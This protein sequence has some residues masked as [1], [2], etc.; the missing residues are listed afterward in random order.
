MTKLAKYI[1]VQNV[2]VSQTLKGSRNFT[3]DQVHLCTEYLGLE[4]EEWTYFMLMFQKEKAGHYKLKDKI[5]S[6]LEELGK[7]FMMV[8]ARF[9]DKERLAEDIRAEFYSSVYYPLVRAAVAIQPDNSK[10]FPMLERFGLKLSV[11]GEHLNK[12]EQMGLIKQTAIGYE[13][14]A[15]RTYL[16]KDSP[17]HKIYCENLEKILKS[18][19]V[20]G[21]PDDNFKYLG[22]ITLSHEAAKKIRKRL[23]DLLEEN[24]KTISDSKSEELR[25]FNIDFRR[26]L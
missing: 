18:E 19:F 8:S 12:L 22:M 2:I 23:L 7:K 17:L 15:N 13:V 24:S 3:L 6:K 1:G 9:K 14:C 26:V 11:A 4:G 10:L 21:F 25:V 5:D 20:E 16:E